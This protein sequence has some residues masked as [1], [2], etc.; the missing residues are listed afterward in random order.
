MENTASLWVLLPLH[1]FRNAI[2]PNASVA[3]N[4]GPGRVTAYFNRNLR[5]LTEYD[6]IYDE[7]EV[8]FLLDD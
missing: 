2:F 7:M 8:S 6:Q 5:E 4:W 3:D 1:N